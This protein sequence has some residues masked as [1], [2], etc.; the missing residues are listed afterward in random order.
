MDWQDSPEQAQFRTEVAEFIQ[1]RLPERYRSGDE[2]SDETQTT[3]WQ[4][5]RK[6]NDPSAKESAI[7]WADVGWVGLGLLVTKLDQILI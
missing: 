2:N 5:D 6:S 3:G 1:T 7:N 4:A